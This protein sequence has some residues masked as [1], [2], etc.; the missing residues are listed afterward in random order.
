MALPHAD[1]QALPV[2]LLQSP[3][4]TL[5]QKIRSKLQNPD[6]LELCHLVPKEVVQLGE[7]QETK[8][9]NYLCF[10]MSCNRGTVA[11]VLWPCSLPGEW[12][13]VDLVV[14]K[15]TS[16]P[17]LIGKARILNPTPGWA[18]H[19]PELGR[20]K[21]WPVI[22]QAPTPN[23]LSLTSA[24]FLCPQGAR[25]MVRRVERRTLRLF[26]PGCSAMAWQA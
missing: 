12:K 3:E 15:W 26:E 13:F 9:A 11:P 8:M 5:S 1:S 23:S 2:S 14:A 20:H 18:S 22:H 21:P 7:A 25:A 17:Q 4:L 24:W 16:P 10:G 6:L 19:G